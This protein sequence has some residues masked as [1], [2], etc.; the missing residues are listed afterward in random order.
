MDTGA[1][2]AV[3]AALFIVIFF[4]MRARD[5]GNERAAETVKTLIRLTGDNTATIFKRGPELSSYLSMKVYNQS[6]YKYNPTTATYTGVTVGGV[7]TGGWTVD[8]AHYSL[9][10]GNVTDRYNLWY[11]GKQKIGDKWEDDWHVLNS[12]TIPQEDVPAAKQAGLERWLNG[13]TIVLRNPISSA[14]Q[15]LIDQVYEQYGQ[16]HDLYST[17]NL[18]SVYATKGMLD[19]EEMRRIYDFL[20]GRS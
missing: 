2:I 19:H 20:C 8:E 3:V 7:T 6:Y 9:E 5:K 11:R 1:A 10:R 16:N 15:A 18:L 4:A 17:S 13:N 14:D 12:V